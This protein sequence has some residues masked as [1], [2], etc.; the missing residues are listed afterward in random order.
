MKNKICYMIYSLSRGGA[1]GQLIELLRRLDRDCFDPSLI[2]WEEGNLQRVQGLVGDVRVLGVE[3]HASGGRSRREYRAALALKRLSTCLSEI[4]PQILH[5]ILS[6]PSILAAF[7]RVT[8]LVPCAIHS[9]RTLVDAYRCKDRIRT[10]ADSIATKVS[11][12]VIGNCGAIIR[13]M[14]TLD[15]V[16][17]SRAQL[18][19][20]GVDTVRFSPQM[21][22]SLRE[23]LGWSDDNFVFGIVANFLPYKRHLDFVQIAA[24]IHAVHPR[25]RFL[26]AGEDRGEM[27]PVEEAVEKAGLGPYT[28][29]LPGTEHPE[30]AFAAMDVYICT[31][32]T[33][34]L[35]NSLLEAMSSGVPVIATDVGGNREAVADGATGFVVPCQTPEAIAKIACELVANPDLL[36]R[37]SS[38]ARRR[39]EE[40]FPMEKMVRAHEEVY[41]R[42][43]E[44]KRASNWARL[45]CRA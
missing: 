35:S 26:L 19:P 7:A 30:R 22:R 42:L 2:L 9:R 12:L 13:E 8:R 20:N 21:E 36:R 17:E 45:T 39:V 6:G 10:I 28:R 25:A 16:P 18:I 31:S 1:E 4:R 41:L 5:A 15:G 29:I 40:L 37:L 14:V 44:E 32:E 24:L 34:G 38:N 11:D 33:E 23:E 43:L 3:R 27:K